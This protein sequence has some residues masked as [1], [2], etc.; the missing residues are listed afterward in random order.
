VGA[1]R[2]PLRAQATQCILVHVQC[3]IRRLSLLRL[4]AVQMHSRTSCMSTT[5][6]QHLSMSKA[7]MCKEIAVVLFN[8]FLT[9]PPS[10]ASLLPAC[11][12]CQVLCLEL[13]C[14]V[15]LVQNSTCATGRIV[16][17]TSFNRNASSDG[18]MYLSIRAGGCR[19]FL[20]RVQPVNHG[21]THV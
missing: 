6:L 1:L 5:I 16:L 7:C 17:R 3:T 8:V 13:C 9:V 2:H 15:C 10:A 21:L 12:Y 14:S 11:P 18:L 4:H 19:S 20:G